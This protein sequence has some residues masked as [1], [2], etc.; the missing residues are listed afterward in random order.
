MLIYSAQDQINLQLTQRTAIHELLMQCG[1][2]SVFIVTKEAS[3]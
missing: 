1:F 3:L 2:S